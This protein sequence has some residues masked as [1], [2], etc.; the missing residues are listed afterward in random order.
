MASATE[1]GYILPHQVN[2]ENMEE[3]EVKRENTEETDGKRESMDETVTKVKRENIGETE[4]FRENMEETEVSQHEPK[5]ADVY[6]GVDDASANHT[7]CSLYCRT[8]SCPDLRNSE[9]HR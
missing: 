4:V 7:L 8:L 3:T 9:E 1:A 5:I 6:S 2:R